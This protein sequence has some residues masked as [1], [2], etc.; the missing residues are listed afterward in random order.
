M[1]ASVNE[2][3]ALVS[4]FSSI[5]ASMD[6]EILPMPKQPKIGTKLFSKFENHG[7]TSNWQYYLQ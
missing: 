1:K 6:F 7:N 4:P 3:A 5:A 2:L